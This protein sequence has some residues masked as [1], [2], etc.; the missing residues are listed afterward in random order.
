MSDLF[1]DSY[2]KTFAKLVLAHAAEAQRRGRECLRDKWCAFWPAVGSQYCAGGLMII[3]RALNGWEDTDFVIEQAKGDCGDLVKRCRQSFAPR[4]GCPLSWV[5]TRWGR[6]EKGQY[7]TS[8]SPIWRMA[9]GLVEHCGHPGKGWSGYLCWNNMMR[10][11]PA[12]G[13][14]PPGWSCDAQRPHAAELLSREIEILRP[15]VIVA[16]TGQD[17]MDWFVVGLDRSVKLNP[18]DGCDYVSAHGQFHGSTVIVA[19]HPMKKKEDVLMDEL[20]RF[21]PTTRGNKG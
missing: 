5:E 17:W 12:C 21:L 1:D 3:G 10:V 15:G 6:G 16:F 14:N 19:P 11:S 7:R 18:V 9:R 8:R 20:R 4:D 13:G 2:E